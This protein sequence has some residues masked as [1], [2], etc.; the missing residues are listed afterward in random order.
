MDGYTQNINIYIILLV[1]FI[2]GYISLTSVNTNLELHGEVVDT[3]Q[4]NQD[5]EVNTITISG[6]G[7]VQEVSSD[8]PI[9]LVVSG[10]NNIITI[11]E[12]TTVDQL[13]VSGVDIEI[14]LPKGSQPIIVDSGV[15]T[16]IKYY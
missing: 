5:S 6:V 9:V 2:V 7:K 14:N 13:V 3:K 11:K 16:K 4:H 10:V 8:V 12:G 1:A 15:R